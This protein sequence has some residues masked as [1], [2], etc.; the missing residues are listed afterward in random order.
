MTNM[1]HLRSITF[2]AELVLAPGKTTAAETLQRI[3][4][5]AFQDPGVRYANFQMVQKGA[6]LTN[7]A[8]KGAVSQALLLH[9]RIRVQDQ[10]TG[11]SR[12]DFAVRVIKLARIALEELDHEAFLAQQFVVQ[13]LVN[14]RSGVTA[15]ENMRDSVLR[16][17]TDD[18]EGFGGSPQMLGLKLHFPGS[19]ANSV[20]FQVRIENFRQDERSLFLENVGVYK[21]RVDGDQTGRLGEL[22]GETYE[23]LEREVI[24]FLGR[25]ERSS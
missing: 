6:A 4:H 13:S 10:N 14:P 7:P 21:E 15:L 16:C 11:S 8:P 12:E 3:H 17:S 1:E 2:L 23:F 22:F 5:R 19:D 18:F 9:D 25:R 20:G 24:A